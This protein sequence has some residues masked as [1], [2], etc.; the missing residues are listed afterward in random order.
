MN[1]HR[2]D[3]DRFNRDLG[4]SREVHFQDGITPDVHAEREPCELVDLFGA[5]A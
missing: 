5:M 3:S 2:M 1:K 4:K